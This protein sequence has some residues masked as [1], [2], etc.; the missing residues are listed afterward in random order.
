MCAAQETKGAKNA[1]GFILLGFLLM[2][3][4]LC[5]IPL[6]VWVFLGCRE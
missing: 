6:G 1:V 5:L 4:I 3:T 2:V